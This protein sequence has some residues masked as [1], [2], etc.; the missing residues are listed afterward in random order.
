[1]LL[2]EKTLAPQFLDGF[3]RTNPS[4]N[5]LNHPIA[6]RSHHM[7]VACLFLVVQVKC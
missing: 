6:R 7:I 1:M 3:V 4:G 5:Y 2:A